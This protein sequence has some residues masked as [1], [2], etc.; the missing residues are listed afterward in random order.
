M[1]LRITWPDKRVTEARTWRGLFEAIRR[2]QWKDMC[3]DALRE[4]LAWR[5]YVWSGKEVDP[6]LRPLA[7][8]LRALA[9]VKLFKLEEIEE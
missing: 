7:S 6:T 8:F 5:A 1:L 2:A 4:E 3:Y 9:E